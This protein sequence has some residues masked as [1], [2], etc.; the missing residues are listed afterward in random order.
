M[1]KVM[2]VEHLHYQKVAQVVG[3]EGGPRWNSDRYVKS[4]KQ[5]RRG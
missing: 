5:L 1:C 4:E 3:G 2:E